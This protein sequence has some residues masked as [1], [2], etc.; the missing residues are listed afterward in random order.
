MGR[1]FFIISFF[2]INSIYAETVKMSFGGKQKI[3]NTIE[4]PNNQGIVFNWISSSS[5]TSKL[6]YLVLVNL[7]ELWN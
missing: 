7:R 5:F 3:E 4:F 1:L 2:V 6:V